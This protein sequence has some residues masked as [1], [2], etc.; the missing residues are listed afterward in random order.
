MNKNKMYIKQLI[1]QN[2]L[3]KGN[4]PKNAFEISPQKKI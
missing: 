1:R 4:K 2:T 3:F